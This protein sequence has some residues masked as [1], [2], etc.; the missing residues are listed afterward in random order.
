MQNQMRQEVNKT[1]VP[2]LAFFPSYENPAAVW[3]PAF[4][5]KE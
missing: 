1:I 5:L 3:T 2:T 4:S